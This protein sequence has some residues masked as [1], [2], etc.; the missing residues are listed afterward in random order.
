MPPART[1]KVAPIAA[2]SPKE[3]KPPAAA[4]AGGKDAKESKE[5]KPASA[6]KP[7]A[8]AVAPVTAAK[9]EVA[10]P[11][12]ARVS[13]TKADVAAAT[14]STT[15]PAAAPRAITPPKIILSATI[16][17]PAPKVVVTAPASAIP[18][19]ILAP[20]AIEGSPITV[21]APPP[22]HSKTGDCRCYAA[23][24]HRAS[25]PSAVS[26][27]PTYP[28][29]CE[30][31]TALL[32]RVWAASQ[33]PAKNRRL[34]DKSGN[35][36]A[37]S[38][39]S[40]GTN[41]GGATNGGTNGGRSTPSGAPGPASPSST[42]SVAPNAWGGA[43]TIGGA[44]AG[45]I[46]GAGAGTTGGAGGAT[47][48]LARKKRDNAIPTVPVVVDY[49]PKEPWVC[50]M[51]R[52]HTTM[53]DS[54]LPAAAFDGAHG[55]LTLQI[56]T[57]QATL[58]EHSSGVLVEA[59][60][61]M[62]AHNPGLWSGMRGMHNKG[63]GGGA[64]VG[65]GGGAPSVPGGAP[66]GGAGAS[67]P[68]TG[69][70]MQLDFPVLH[71][72]LKYRGGDPPC[73]LKKLH[74]TPL[75]SF[76]FLSPAAAQTAPPADDPLLRLLSKLA[77]VRSSAGN[78]SKFKPLIYSCALA[79]DTMFNPLNQ[80]FGQ[81]PS[82]PP[83]A[84]AAAA[85]APAAAH[86]RGGHPHGTSG[87]TNAISTA[88]VSA[89][90]S[91]P[92]ASSSSE[93]AHA[94]PQ[95][96]ARSY[97]LAW[98]WLKEFPASPHASCADRSGPLHTLLGGPA[99]LPLV[100]LAVANSGL[101]ERVQVWKDER[102]HARKA[103]EAGVEAAKLSSAAQPQ[104]E[105]E[106]D[107]SQCKTEE[108][109]RASFRSP[110][111]KLNFH[112]F[113]P[114]HIA[115]SNMEPAAVPATS[116]S[117][118]SAKTS[119]DSSPSDTLLPVLDLLLRV[120]AVTF[121]TT[122]P[123]PIFL[124]VLRNHTHVTD[125]A[126]KRLMTAFPEALNLKFSLAWDWGRPAVLQ[127][128]SLAKVS[129]GSGSVLP[130][131]LSCFLPGS[132]VHPIQ[133]LIA[134]RGKNMTVELMQAAMGGGVQREEL[135]RCTDARGQSLLQLMIQCRCTVEVV[136]ALLA[137]ERK[138]QAGAPAPKDG[139]PSSYLLRH[140]S[141][142][143]HLPLHTAAAAVPVDGPLLKLLMTLWPQ[144]LSF[145]TRD[146]L[147]I[148]PLQL[149]LQRGLRHPVNAPVY[150]LVVELLKLYPRALAD[151][152]EG[153]SSFKP[154]Q[155][156]LRHGAP[157]KLLELLYKHCPLIF[158]TR[159]FDNWTPFH[160]F[161]IAGAFTDE[162]LAHLPPDA[163]LLG[164][165]PLN[166]PKGPSP[167]L[168]ILEFMVAHCKDDLQVAEGRGLETPLHL[169]LKRCPFTPVV[170]T[171][172]SNY[173]KA[174]R[175]RNSDNHLPI[176]VAVSVN[177]GTLAAISSK[178][179]FALTA[180]PGSEQLL[181][182]E[183]TPGAT[184]L[185]QLLETARNLPGE[186]LT[187]QNMKL[188][189]EAAQVLIQ[190]QPAALCFGKALSRES[191]GKDI[192]SPALEFIRMCLNFPSASVLK[193]IHE[194][195]PEAIYCTHIGETGP[196][197]MQGAT[198]LHN[199]AGMGSAACV[200]YICAHAPALLHRRNKVNLLPIESFAKNRCSSA[201][202]T[203]EMR[204]PFLISMLKLSRTLWLQDNTGDG[205][206]ET[207][208]VHQI[209]GEEW[210]TPIENTH[211]LTDTVLKI[212]EVPPITAVQA[213]SPVV[214]STPIALTVD[215]QSVF[216]WLI[217]DLQVFN[218]VEFSIA[219]MQERRQLEQERHAHATGGH[220]DHD[221][222]HSHD[223]GSSAGRATPT[224]TPIVVDKPPVFVQHAVRGTVSKLEDKVDVLLDQELAVFAKALMP[225]VHAVPQMAYS[226]TI[227]GSSILCCAIQ[228]ND[229]YAVR[230][231][232][233]QPIDV[234]SPGEGGQLPID[235]CKKATQPEM[236]AVLTK[237]MTK[238]R[239]WLGRY[240]MSLTDRPIWG[241]QHVCEFATEELDPNS[242]EAA[243]I[244]AAAHRATPKV[245]E[246]D[247]DHN[248]DDIAQHQVDFSTTT[249]TRPVALKF[250]AHKSEWESCWTAYSRLTALDKNHQFIAQCYG[251]FDKAERVFVRDHKE[252]R[253]HF[254]ISMERGQ[255]NLGM[256]QHSYVQ[257][258]GGSPSIEILQDLA[259][260]LQ[261]ALH[262]LHSQRLVHADV[263]L[264]NV[265]VVGDNRLRLIDFDSMAEFGKPIT[266]FTPWY[267]PPEKAKAHV[268]GKVLKADP[269]FD[270]WQFGT[271]LF[272]LA[273]GPGEQ[274]FR[275]LQMTDE[276][277][278]PDHLVQM[279][280]NESFVND[281]TIASAIK[282]CFQQET[283]EQLRALLLKCLKVNPHERPTIMELQS[284]P[285][286]IKQTGLGGGA[287][288]IAA[289][290]TTMTSAVTT[291][292][293]TMHKGFEK[294][295]E[296]MTRLDE[297]LLA[298]RDEMRQANSNILDS[299]SD[300][301]G[302]VL[303]VKAEVRL[304]AQNVLRN[305]SSAREKSFP[306]LFLMVPYASGTSVFS[307]FMDKLSLK[308]EYRLVF[309]CEGGGQTKRK[310]ESTS[311]AASW[312]ASADGASDPR[313]SNGFS[314]QCSPLAVNST[315][316][317]RLP[318]EFLKKALPV[319][320]AVHILLQVD[321]V[322]AKFVGIPLPC[323]IPFFEKLQTSGAMQKLADL[324]NTEGGSGYAA[325]LMD[326]VSGAIAQGE[327][328]A[329]ADSSFGT[330]TKSNDPKT[331]AAY[332]EAYDAVQGLLSQSDVKFGQDAE[333]CGLR[334]YT[335]MEGKP[336]W[337]CPCHAQEMR[338]AGRLISAG[339]E[340]I[341]AAR[342][343]TPVGAR[344]SPSSAQA[345]VPFRSHPLPPQIAT[346]TPSGPAGRYL[347]ATPS[348]PF[349]SP[350]TF[351][352]APQLPPMQMVM[353][354]LPGAVMDE[355]EA[356]GGFTALHQQQAI[357]PHHQ[358]MM[359]SQLA[360]TT[361]LLQSMKRL[362]EKHNELMLTSKQPKSRACTI[363]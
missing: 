153:K 156:A 9:E 143:G 103:K 274:L 302:A 89:T 73:L 187:E 275:K 256:W 204:R 113:S 90:H 93:G 270:T 285:F 76:S 74:A 230:L 20:Q 359:H 219:R 292:A 126:L 320:K 352:P 75:E 310:G 197:M 68:G 104:E 106:E 253:F 212:C 338:A 132:L 360:A 321:S 322:A 60:L 339:S 295:H 353:P 244:L 151:W 315:I 50:C 234:L 163:S 304:Q 26:N 109:L 199:A 65:G 269:T 46:G 314:R 335:D 221:H 136:D 357:S 47:G 12:V 69:R 329:S 66:A 176:H 161:A 362:E 293:T 170:T 183:C 287:A 58:E 167:D 289:A 34:A 17:A 173:M 22:A 266:E 254:C 279:W 210:Y 313:L 145:P 80:P 122:A 55:G 45:T 166:G 347:V 25:L 265:I 232:L 301:K 361:A 43:G 37:T 207:D 87:L 247:E 142:H 261:K 229:L 4:P 356:G 208:Y 71:F 263:K 344:S 190:Q 330:D 13:W 337:L 41:G 168:K 358:A 99:N 346:S 240:N 260:Q 342:P 175:M 28:V 281:G 258:H 16:A 165:G 7:K 32:Q 227:A 97:R 305:L 24:D 72:T 194:S 224:P 102:E 19:A 111:T 216:S 152:A 340:G 29:L 70:P 63:G 79:A 160:V 125:D 133:A 86:G 85:D 296:D 272:E 324:Y 231:L 325:K 21:T 180:F 246:E 18:S 239:K 78:I 27:A 276:A 150:D 123:H 8:P 130:G 49:E 6:S 311:D 114:F 10:S 101:E 286:F 336:V 177:R 94:L 189:A 290:L 350:G 271:L 203:P 262:F 61:F 267:V 191:P 110:L 306:R 171:M 223:T 249:L 38:S 83:A 23:H 297:N 30:A 308:D 252:V 291:V 178:L 200:E 54:V 341:A 108:E 149:L 127:I 215:Q 169:A 119:S 237:A 5:S 205:G 278:K 235:H 96:R 241:G 82:A 218:D 140:Y 105:E 288:T 331:Q 95:F 48:S 319:L 233:Q 118:C 134:V 333:L 273:L 84:P 214:P 243:L 129:S 141:S 193:V 121:S 242:Q 192:P 196:P 64:Q 228:C 116:S 81:Q 250:F 248:E 92:A 158:R 264:S 363:Q 98:F 307:K 355:G 44:G 88:I 59:L 316:L 259:I 277:G 326:N 323:G 181:L 245:E 42:L 217:H 195:W 137:I 348:S 213:A 300:V 139:G 182:A 209:F 280:A 52:T 201:A 36:G 128:F 162:S 284:D 332:E 147:Q 131:A 318:S 51:T 206:D 62:L 282:R 225:L 39:S 251:H 135:I 188:L 354:F 211:L 159:E 115:C 155:W 124:A 40:G 303:Q 309:L 298:M 3:S 112:G 57:E 144:S 327:A 312:E 107:D 257:T 138:L 268:A 184:P 179:M 35:G 186:T 100:K 185:V 120:G 117:V 328:R 67:G 222:H 146:M 174:A 172:L 148:L 226:M 15:A 157:L 53:C 351:S 299:V 317:V 283:H 2:K 11:N 91:T 31:A 334:C 294:N 164:P 238:A 77:Q 220:G 236:H 345:V 255:S 56:I 349:I 33:K 14:P 202:F 154:A 343:V 1:A 198:L